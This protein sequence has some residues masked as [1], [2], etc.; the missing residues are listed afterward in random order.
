MEKSRPMPPSPMNLVI[1][2]SAAICAK[3]VFML[4]VPL[5]FLRFIS[6]SFA[7][8]KFREISACSIS[9]FVSMSKE[10]LNSIGLFRESMFKVIFRSLMIVFSCNWWSMNVNFP[11]LI[12]ALILVSNKNAG[13]TRGVYFGFST[14]FLDISGTGFSTISGAGIGSAGLLISS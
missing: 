5:A 13:I 4:N 11:L 9:P 1:S 10:L 12:F 14:G 6:P 7:N 2:K 8:D 3:P